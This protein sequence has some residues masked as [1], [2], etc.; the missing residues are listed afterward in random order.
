MVNIQDFQKHFPQQYYD[1]GRIKRKPKIQNKLSNDFDKLFFNFLLI[2][3]YE[4]SI[5]YT[6]KEEID[7]KYKISQQMENFEYKKKKDVIH[8]LCFE[9]KI[10]LKSLDCLA[11]FFKVNLLYSHCF[12]YY[13]MFYNPISLLYYHVNHNKDMFLVQK[14][15]IEENHCNG[16]EIDNIHKPLYSA[17]HYKLT[18]I[19]NMME[20]L[21][22]NHDNKK[23]QDCYEYIKTYIDEVLI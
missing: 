2:V 1:M 19:Y 6:K 20:K 7:I 11:T 8:N 18:D 22:L 21:H 5:H 3:K 9:E 23:K 4:I 15:T 14:D 17:S 16:Y 12:V 10:N 13:K